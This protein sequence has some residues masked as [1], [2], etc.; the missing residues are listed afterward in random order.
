M[1][2]NNLTNFQSVGEFHKVF[3]HPQPTAIQKNI[4]HE[5][6]KLIQFRLN[7]IKEEFNELIDAVEKKNMTE[8]IDALG[9]ILYVVYGMGQ[10]LGVDL[11]KV[12]KIVHASNMS[13]LCNNLNEVNDTLE[14]YK[15][16][17]GFENIQIGYRLA[18]DN[19]HYVIYNAQTD[20]ILKSKFF[21]LPNFGEILGDH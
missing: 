18:P 16:L 3:G 20:K 5:N 13:K 8:L 9:D 17:P 2:S 1:D 4:L 21:T 14:H 12:F 15:S 11:D 19:E 10:A 7:L 6:P